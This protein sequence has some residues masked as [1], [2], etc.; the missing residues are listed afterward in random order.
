[1]VQKVDPGAFLFLWVLWLIKQKSHCLYC[2]LVYVAWSLIFQ[3]S[4]C[5]KLSFLQYKQLLKHPLWPYSTW[6]GFLRMFTLW[7]HW[8]WNR[9]Q[10]SELYSLEG[11]NALCLEKDSWPKTHY[12]PSGNHYLGLLLSNFY[13]L[14][15]SI[16]HVVLFSTGPLHSLQ[17]YSLQCMFLCEQSWNFCFTSIHSSYLNMG[18]HIHNAVLVLSFSVCWG[19]ELEKFRKLTS[20]GVVILKLPFKL[21]EWWQYNQ[22]WR[23]K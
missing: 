23:E 21:C 5:C 4:L 16:K 15:Y 8:F 7:F 19:K 17:C 14:Y 1:M 11:S 2:Y 3:P 6:T 22:L 18:R 20:S 10:F 9:K 13:C 12:N